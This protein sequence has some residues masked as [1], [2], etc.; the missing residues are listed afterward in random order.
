MTDWY[1]ASNDNQQLGPVAGE[2]LVNLFNTGVISRETLVWR[3]GL[4]SWL[5]LRRLL[6][7]LGLREA[8]P[9]APAP[10]VAATLATPEPPP[11]PPEVPAPV[12]K[13]RVSSP[14]HIPV[15][16]VP[17]PRTGMSGCAIAVIV[18]AVIAVPVIAILAAIAIPAY[19]SYRQ[20]AGISMVQAEAAAL[21]PA[22]VEFHARNG[23]CPDNTSAGFKPA[24]SYASASIASIK[25]GQFEDGNCGL[26]VAMR[27]G[28]LEGKLLWLEYAGDDWR[29]SSEVK[30]ELLP[31]NCRSH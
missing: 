29:C 21:K 16:S 10:V 17:P 14:A 1:Y 19:N 7:E 26:E 11:Q 3:E 9:S 25:L 23:S 8:Q 31:V 28:E 18:V 6:D 27:G 13:P 30:D 4:D 2:H 24:D 22:I 12:A 15:T 5:P 20:R